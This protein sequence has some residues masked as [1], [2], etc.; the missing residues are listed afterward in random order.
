MMKTST[1]TRWRKIRI[2]GFVSLFH[3]G[4][5]AFRIRYTEPGTGKDVRHRLPVDTLE[6]AKKIVRGCN[7]E[8]GNE[9]KIPGMKSKVPKKETVRSSLLEALKA[10]GGNSDTQ[11]R[12]MQGVNR[13]LKFL[14]ARYPTVAVWQDIR[15]S[16]CLAWVKAMDEEG[17]AYDTFRLA[18]VPIKYASTYWH[19]EMAYDDVMAS[20]LVRSRVRTVRKNRPQSKTGTAL[21]AK[22][23]TAFM[24][25]LKENKPLLY[26]M[27]MLMG[28]A[29]LRMF[30]AAYL[31]RCDVDFTNG[32]VTVDKTPLHTPKNRPSHRAIPVHQA[33]LQAV[34]DHLAHSKVQTIGDELFTHSGGGP[35]KSNGLFSAWRYAMIEA[36]A[37]CGLPA[38]FKA[39][40]LRATFVTL[41]R[42]A[43]ADYPILKQ[44]IGHTA[45]DMIGEHYESVT[46]AD[47]RREVV[48]VFQSFLDADV[49]NLA[50]PSKTEAESA[51]K[52]NIIG[53]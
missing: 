32:T 30:E 36:R 50:E 4:E 31:R 42:R 34:R 49:N 5:T 8:I 25:W 53:L 20:K 26:P 41:S 14:Q 33:A 46:V 3:D 21:T 35:W 13:F 40:N 27:A 47:L 10:M 1:S 22:E 48:D 6:E 24:E 52:V 29:G 12:A 7:A 15:P 16:M 17:M 44:Y 39:R 19:E 23:L 51:L 28:L 11:A 43:K 38:D 37:A 2:P 18:L 45:G 9:R